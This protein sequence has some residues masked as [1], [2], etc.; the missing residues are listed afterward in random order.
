MKKVVTLLLIVVFVL[1]MAGCKDQSKPAETKSDK[2]ATE[3]DTAKTDE[4]TDEKTD[5]KPEPA[6]ESLVA[7]QEPIELSIFYFLHSPFK[8]EY[9]VNQEAAKLTNVTLKGYVSQSS[10]NN[11]EAF[12]LMVSTQE[13]ADIVCW[14][15][16]KISELAQ[17]GA[18]VPLDDLIDQHA[19]HIKAFFEQYPEI[20]AHV[21]SSDGHIYS[22]PFVPDGDAA[23]GWFIRHDWLKKLNLEVPTNADELHEALV[24]FREKDPNGNGK[25]DEIPYFN[26]DSNPQTVFADIAQLWGA[27]EGWYEVDGKVKYGPMEPEYKEA[28]KNLAAWMA[29]GLFDPEI[30]TRG[31]EARDYMLKENLGGMT[32]DWFAS[33]SGYNSKS[34][35]EGFDFGAFAP[36]A[37]K[38]GNAYERTV[39][40]K[41][42]WSGWG[43]AASNPHPEETMKY[44]DFWFTEVGRRL[45]N[46]GIENETY[47]LVDGEP[48]FTE[49]I[50]KADDP[51]LKLRDYGCQ[52]TIGV[53]QDFNYEKQLMNE[54]ALQ[55]VLL[56][57]ENNYF[58][59]QFPASLPYTE[60]ERERLAELMVAIDT[61]KQ[62]T[63]QKWVLGTEAVD[64]GYD[65]FKSSLENFGIQ[66]AIEIQQ[67]AFDRY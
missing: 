54:T 53:Q 23:Q 32:H 15:N 55:G 57:A 27:K 16:A 25:Q 65:V 43:I 26:R 37:D 11:K 7:S 30:Y 56:Y 1:S 40:S 29:E 22:I 44:F 39:R 35:I 49:T 9:P 36:P 20:K 58:G 13:L 33:T 2:S 52:M 18:F 66:E 42:Y 51:V 67:A 3:K 34:E 10:A 59:K 64:A 48:V 4:K 17:Q 8:D 47:T 5:A 50:L 60:E 38:D 46:F 6:A 63:A 28:Y 12:T 21:T 62:E 31:K 19:P 24:A 45:L 61:L 14:D 41:L